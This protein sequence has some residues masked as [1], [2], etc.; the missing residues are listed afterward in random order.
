MEGVVPYS[1]GRVGTVVGRGS[2]VSVGSG[3]CGWTGV[4][5]STHSVGRVGTVGG[6]GSPV[7]PRRVGQ[8]SPVSVGRAGTVG[9]RGPR[10]VSVGRVGTVVGSP[11]S[12]RPR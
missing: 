6:R 11:V 8:G 9:G 12:P 3:D 2:P 7:S 10:P 5:L 1:V 4:V